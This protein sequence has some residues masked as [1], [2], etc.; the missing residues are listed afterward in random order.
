MRY[1]CKGSHITSHLRP[2]SRQCPSFWF[3]NIPH[4]KAQLTCTATQFVA[5]TSSP[6]VTSLPTKVRATS[7]HERRVLWA[8]IVPFT[9][10][11]PDVSCFPVL[12]YLLC[13]RLRH[14]NAKA[15]RRKAFAL[16]SVSLLNIVHISQQYS[17]SHGPWVF[18]LRLMPVILISAVVY[19]PPY[20]RR[21]RCITRSR[22]IG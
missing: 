10:L 1:P 11:A 2:P 22:C 18:W 8:S 12:T 21:R 5:W 9:V 19:P 17:V 16:L 20:T 3:T 6:R 7:G 4:R 14:D 15:H 13:C